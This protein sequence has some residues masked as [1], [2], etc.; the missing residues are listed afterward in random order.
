MTR[1]RSCGQPFEP[2]K[3]YHRYC[4]GCWS[5]LQA[6]RRSHTDPLMRRYPMRWLSADR[7]LVLAL[8]AFGI[9]AAY[10]VLHLLGLL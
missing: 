5:D 8:I 1:C 3:P 10:A 7:L 9:F 2:R 4:D 6:E